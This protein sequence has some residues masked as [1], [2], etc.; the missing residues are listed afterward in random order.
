[1]KNQ[2]TLINKNKAIQEAYVWSRKF[3]KKRGTTYEFIESVEHSLYW[4]KLKHYLKEH[5]ISVCE[6][7][8]PLVGSFDLPS[9]PSAVISLLWVR[10]FLA[11]NSYGRQSMPKDQ[12][13]EIY[14]EDKNHG[15]PAG[16][17]NYLQIPPNEVDLELFKRF[18]ENGGS[19]GTL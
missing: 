3:F 17:S 9:Y 18:K 12:L 5:G 14:A 10:L 1:L 15:F 19:H 2:N 4:K 16:L 7:G 8:T 6:S 13:L 11:I